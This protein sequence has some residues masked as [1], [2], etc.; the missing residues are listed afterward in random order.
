MGHNEYD[1]PEDRDTE[2]Y[3]SRKVKRIITWSV[4]G[5][6][7]LITLLMTFFTVPAG[8]VGVITRFTAV[9]RVAYPGLGI[10]IPWI[11]G[12][13]NMD[14]RTQ[15]LQVDASAASLN[16]QTVSSTI[17]VNYHLDGQYATWIY[18]NVGRN[19]MDIVVAPAIQ[20]TFKA[21]TA[22]FTAE[23]LINSREVVRAQAEKDLRAKLA[24]YHIIVEAF[25]IVNFDFSPEFNTAIEQKQV[26]QQAVETAK[27]KLAQA[28]IDA[29]TAV[30][31]AQGQADSQVAIAEGQAKAQK[32]LKDNGALTPEYLQYVFLQKW[33][34]KLPVVMGQSGTILDINS[35]VN[36]AK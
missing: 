25:N 1:S 13:T 8:A 4:L 7:T 14:V 12:I 9:N 21:T 31:Q 29:K 15:K 26:A 5:V 20:N 2:E 22:Q 36:T 35:L 23:Q 33:D 10:K 16:M 17:A 19:Y 32:A 30:A 34:G 24:P 3:Q 11:E 18:Q 6:F 27:Q 28:E